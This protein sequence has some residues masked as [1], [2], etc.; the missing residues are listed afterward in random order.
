MFSPKK[1]KI[2]YLIT[3]GN[4]GGAQRY[5]FELAQSLPKNIFEVTVVMGEGRELREKLNRLG[6]RTIQLESL[7][8][9]IKIGADWKTFRLLLRIIGQEKPDIIH[10]NSSKIGGL[11]ALAG[12]LTGVSK[13]IFTIHGLAFNEDRPSWQKWLIKL[14]HWLSILLC[15]QIIVVAKSLKKQIA[16]WPGVKNKIT[17]IPNGLENTR[18]FNRFVARNEL[19]NYF[20]PEIRQSKNK[21]AASQNMQARFWIGTISELHKNKGLDIL[22]EAFAGVV[23]SMLGN[24]LGWSLVLAIIGDGDEKASLQKLIHDKRLED[25]IFLLGRIPDARNYLNALDIFTL[26]SRTEALPYTILEAGAAGL[27]VIASDVGGISEIIPE[28]EYGILVPP[29][30][31]KEVEKSLLYLIKK[32]EY[33]KLAGTNLKKRIS[34]NFSIKK[35]VEETVGLYQNSQR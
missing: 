3:K 11:G 7:G 14:S 2:F 16:S 6:I 35:M 5:V 18:F 34:E 24:S 4:F 23:K 12:R 22:I 28:P 8:R 21:N 31:V 32:P 1:I 20:P 19:L 26:T 9:D 30:N 33:R 25:R 27:P 13:I 17:I 15:H 10:L 29:G